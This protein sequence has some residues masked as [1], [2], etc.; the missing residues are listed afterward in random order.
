MD[1][2][3]YFHL[4]SKVM[5]DAAK[6]LGSRIRLLRKSLGLT[7]IQVSQAAGLSP[8]GFQ[9]IERGESFPKLSSLESIASALKVRPTDLMA[10]SVPGLNGHPGDLMNRLE[11]IV[12]KG[13]NSDMRLSPDEEKL[14]QLLRLCDKRF[15]KSIFQTVQNTV[16]ESGKR[17]LRR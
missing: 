10:S 12:S 6:L 8:L 17:S 7:Q 4:K 3:R 13:P 9:K 2:H 11:E 16:Y 15:F 14:I 5:D 1:C